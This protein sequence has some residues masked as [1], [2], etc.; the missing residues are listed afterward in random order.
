MFAKHC[1]FSF[2]S[3]LVSLPKTCLSPSFPGYFSLGAS[4][5]ITNLQ[6]MLCGSVCLICGL[7]MIINDAISCSQLQSP[8]AGVAN[9]FQWCMVQ[10]IRT[11]QLTSPASSVPW[12]ELWQDEIGR[13]LGLPF[14][15]FLVWLFLVMLLFHLFLHHPAQVLTLPETQT[16]SQLPR[17]CES[18]SPHQ[19]A[20]PHPQRK[21][22]RP[23]REFT[24]SV[25]TRGCCAV[26][27]VFFF[28]GSSGAC[29]GGVVVTSSQW[30]GISWV[31]SVG[32]ARALCACVA[33]LIVLCIWW[34]LME[35]RGGMDSGGR[36]DL[37]SMW[38]WQ[39]VIHSFIQ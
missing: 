36:T 21:P 7:V 35:T 20:L 17:F 6:W 37:C 34:A 25:P 5:S 22:D 2:L 39:E 1:F 27:T 23:H 10:K 38:A 3:L 31:R 16:P 24:P 4:L 8:M 28:K 13:T 9:T 15:L 33:L 19:L 14:S 26:A 18:S 29:W 12:G 30:R 11:F 32:R